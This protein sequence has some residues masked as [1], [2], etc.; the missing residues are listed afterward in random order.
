MSSKPHDANDPKYTYYRE[1]RAVLGRTRGG[2]DTPLQVDRTYRWAVDSNASL[3]ETALVDVVYAGIDCALALLDSKKGFLSLVDVG[4]DAV[5]N[6]SKV[7]GSKP[8]CIYDGDLSVG[9][10]SHWAHHFLD[11]LWKRFVDIRLTDTLPDV[12][13]FVA[14]A[15][16]GKKAHWTDWYSGDAGTLVLNKDVCISSIPNC[17]EIILT[18]SR[19]L[20]L[21]IYMTNASQA[22]YGSDDG[23]IFDKHMFNLVIAITHELVICFIGFLSG[24]DKPSVSSMKPGRPWGLSWQNDMFGGYIAI[25]EEPGHT[26]GALHPGTTWLVDENEIGRKINGIAKKKPKSGGKAP[27][28]CLQD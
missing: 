8:Q 10:M 7:Q 27:S 19:L 6:W 28:R 15:P 26:L 9:C 5:T 20:K 13:K 11:A 22:A 14:S 17:L 4:I 12:G 2:K 25:Y 16:L 3:H 24:T 21:I 1:T 18:R 23:E